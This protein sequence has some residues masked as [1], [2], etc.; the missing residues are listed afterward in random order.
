MHY[1][2]IMCY[3]K[4]TGEDERLDWTWTIEEAEAWMKSYQKDDEEAAKAGAPVDEYEYFIV[5]ID[6]EDEDDD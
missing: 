1:Y 6:E 4:R 3:N 2:N 5:E